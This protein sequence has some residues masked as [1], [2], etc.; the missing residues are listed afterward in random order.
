MIPNVSAVYFCAASSENLDRINQDIQ[1]AVYDIY[2]LNF[3]TPMNREKLESLANA[4]VQANSVAHIHTVYD[5]YLNFITL[6]DDFFILKHKCGFDLSY[7]SMNR[8]FTNNIE[9][10]EIIESLVDGLFSVFITLG[11]IPIIRCLPNSAAEMVARKLEK[12]IREDLWDSRNSLFQQNINHSSMFGFQRMLLIILDRNEDIVTPLRH[13]WTYQALTH[14]VLN[15][16]LN[17]IIFND[18]ESKE[19]E[20]DSKDR[21]W[22]S[23]KASPFPSVAEAIQ[24]ELNQYRLFESDIKNLKTSVDTPLLDDK[25][26]PLLMKDNTIKLSSAVNSLPELLERKRL[27]DLHTK[28]AT[29]I[30]HIIKERHLDT[31]FEIEGKILSKTAIDRAIYEVLSDPILGTPDD[32]MRLFLIYCMCHQI[33]D[34]EYSKFENVLKSA[35]CDL[36]PIYYIQRWKSIYRSNKF[37]RYEGGET[38]TVGMFSKLVTHGSSFVMEG[39]KNLV[40][41]RHVSF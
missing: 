5:Q 32:K 6:E 37:N 35:G 9:V 36:S 31:Y 34:A 38:K 23:H 1:D 20:M 41:K 11:N 21:F 39:V 2:H 40:L 27:I 22:H 14:D 10:E 24:D 12:K 7:F 13:T 29:D 3:L 25:N 16:D 4:A 15:F 19:V 26:E 8:A 17:R 33:N 28:I 30:L 18:K